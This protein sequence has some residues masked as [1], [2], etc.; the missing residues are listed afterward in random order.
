MMNHIKYAEVW[1]YFE[2]L[3]LTHIMTRYDD[4]EKERLMTLI[5]YDKK[6]WLASKSNGD[7]WDQL[8]ENGPVELTVWGEKDAGIVTA[9]GYTKSVED[10]VMKTR[11]S[12]TIPWF[13]LF[14]DSPTDS[15]FTLLQIEL[16]LVTVD[17]PNNGG[18]FT[19][20]FQ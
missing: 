1:K 10:L 8:K 12:K 4:Q 13:D 9:V 5:A 14:W 16:D 7:H 19:I 20:P 15:D 17:N 11:L 2:G 6:L 18:S 3:P